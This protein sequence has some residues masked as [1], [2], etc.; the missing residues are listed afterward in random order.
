MC[1]KDK[2][3]AA[4]RAYTAGWAMVAMAAI[5]MCS[6]KKSVQQNT[7]TQQE[8]QRQVWQGMPNL[9]KKDADRSE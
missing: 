9:Q 6:E 3:C 1:S 2:V 5:W 7:R 8:K 4:V